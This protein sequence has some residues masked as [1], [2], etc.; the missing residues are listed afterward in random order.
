MIIESFKFGVK[1]IFRKD[2]LLLS[3][4]LSLPIFIFY[5]FQLYFAIQSELILSFALDIAL[6]LYS[7]IP[8]IIFIFIVSEQLK[9]KSKKGKFDVSKILN[10]LKSNYLKILAIFIIIGLLSTILFLPTIVTGFLL[11]ATETNLAIWLLIFL[12]NLI[13]AIY[14]GLRLVLA[15]YIAVIDKKGIIDSLKFAWKVSKGEVLK[16]FL[17]AFIFQLLLLILFF[18]PIFMAY[19]FLDSF[20]IILIGL[21]LFHILNLIY[22]P[23]AY[24][25][26]Y[27]KALRKKK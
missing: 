22:Y 9:R 8:L 25:Y 10:T 21:Y 27:L 12:V 20:V 4:L 18:I 1:N 3:A 19:F 16:I 15:S 11:S 6:F 26:F 23:S 13:L 7:P 17:I 5:L 24:T 14:I 2:F